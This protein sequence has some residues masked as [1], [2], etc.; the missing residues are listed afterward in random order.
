M[1][2]DELGDV[3]RGP[4]LEVRADDLDAGLQR[5][6]GGEHL[7]HR[8]RPKG[9]AIDIAKQIPM[10]AGLGGGSSDAATTLV[11]LNRLWGLGLARDDLADGAARLYTA[12]K[13][14]WDVYPLPAE[15]ERNVM[16]QEQTAHFVDVVNGKA[17]PS[18]T[19]EDGIQVMRI[20]TSV[21]ESQKTGKLIEL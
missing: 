1:L 2:A 10:Q 7:G 5:V 14:D 4:V 19:L 9:V 12:E 11:A 18:C 21:H 20:I 16:F 15:W 13:K 8:G 17:E 6:V 3:D